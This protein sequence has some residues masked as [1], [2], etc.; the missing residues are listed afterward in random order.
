MITFHKS[1]QPRSDSDA[2][3]KRRFAVVKLWPGVNAAE[4]E[5]IARIKLAANKIGVECVPVDAQGRLLSAP[6]LSVD[7]TNVDFVLHLHFD[8]P[9]M[10]DAHSIVALWNPTRF[11]H[12]WGYHR[13]TRNLLTHD[14]FVS[15]GSSFADDHVFRIIRNYHSHLPPEMRLYH[16]T[17]AVQHQ[18]SLGDTKLFYIGINWEA[19]NGGVSRHQEVLRA[20]DKSGDL[21]I[22]GPEIFQGTKVWDGYQSYVGSLPFDGT[23]VVDEIARSGVALVFSSADHKASEIMSNR[24]FEAVS[25]GAVVICDENKWA[26]RNFGDCLLYVDFSHGA[27][28]VVSQVLSHLRWIRENP[29]RALEMASAA[30]KKFTSGYSLI[31]SLSSIYS[32]LPD[33][34]ARLRSHRLPAGESSSVCCFLLMPQIDMEVLRSH[35]ASARRQTYKN[36][37]YF[38]VVRVGVAAFESDVLRREA[39]SLATVIEAEFFDSFSQG[40]TGVDGLHLGRA[41]V[42]L[43]R[44]ARAFDLTTFVAPNERLYSNHIEALVGALQHNPLVVCAC[45]AA[46]IF[47]EHG[48][49]NAV[50]ELVDFGH[51]DCANPPGMGRFM[52]RTSLIPSDVHLALRY[53]RG[54]P[55]APLVGGREM[56][57]LLN[58]T[59][60]IRNAIEFP[61]REW[62][63]ADE[64]EIIRGYSPSALRIYYGLQP[65]RV[66][67]CE[68]TISP[69]AS[70]KSAV[71]VPPSSMT[72]TELIIFAGRHPRWFLGQF[73]LIYREGLSRRLGVLRK[74]VQLRRPRDVG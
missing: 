12:V 39:G 20:L 7:R 41:M 17:P 24:L 50:S 1:N 54:R 22:Y 73:E 37:S 64:N 30:Q 66:V 48:H 67:V 18:P 62:N 3:L 8:T 32:E 16:S 68:T 46:L 44:E 51:V 40:F 2:S 55:L 36:V 70:A 58:A 42:S 61:P 28:T 33:R 72:L 57:Q 14:D 19:I 9:K 74:I 11:Y 29:S 10:Y 69:D 4:D 15:C 45:T 53:L 38:I 65:P 71:A 60:E 23:S 49:P 59:V 35:L 34:M 26:R 13:T 31:S 21:R 63:D 27:E 52:F 6:C 43:L 47:G 56:L 5:C 25:A